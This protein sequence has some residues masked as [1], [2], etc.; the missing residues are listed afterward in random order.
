[1]KQAFSGAYLLEGGGRQDTIFQFVWE[2]ICIIRANDMTLGTQG[3]PS[4]NFY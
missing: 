1:M 2:F 3:Q 4:A